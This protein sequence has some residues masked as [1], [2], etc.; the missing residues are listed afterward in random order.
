[1]KAGK[2]NRAKGKEG[3]Q[4]EMLYFHQQSFCGVYVC[5]LAHWRV[6]WC[7]QTLWLMVIQQRTTS[8]G[9]LQGHGG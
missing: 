2:N 7:E 8:Y 6:L 4:R 5:R 3:N 1:M 9:I